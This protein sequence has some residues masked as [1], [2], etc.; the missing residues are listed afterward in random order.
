MRA[1]PAVAAGPNER[2]RYIMAEDTTRRSTRAADA[3]LDEPA[4]DDPGGA[5]AKGYS[6]DPRPEAP[7]ADQEPVPLAP[8]PGGPVGIRQVEKD[9]AQPT[10]RDDSPPS[11]RATGP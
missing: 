1:G 5:H 8:L 4:P 9:G 2:R 3:R 7:G 6:A 10:G 11:P